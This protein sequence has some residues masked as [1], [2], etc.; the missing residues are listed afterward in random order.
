MARNLRYRVHGLTAVVY[1]LRSESQPDRHYVGLTSD[2]T[3]A[4]V[5][6]SRS[7]ISLRNAD[8]FEFLGKRTPC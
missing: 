8:S 1:I 2:V 7:G 3:R 5:G 6:R 4:R